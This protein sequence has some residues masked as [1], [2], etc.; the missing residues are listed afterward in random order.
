MTQIADKTTKI[1]LVI[2]ALGIP[3]WS[4]QAPTPGPRPSLAPKLAVI[5]VKD[6]FPPG[7]SGHSI[8]EVVD[9]L[10]ASGNSRKKSEFETSE[11][12]KSRG[13]AFLQQL[14]ELFFV[15]D[16]D[17]IV[18][19]DA[20]LQK[21]K[22][23]LLVHSEGRV[24]LRHIFYDLPSYIGTN[25]FG[26]SVLVRAQKV[27]SYGLLLD[28]DLDNP[29]RRFS[30]S[31]MTMAADRA[32]D[33]KPHLRLVLRCRVTDP[34]VDVKLA[35]DK[36]TFSDPVDMTRQTQLVH[37][38]LAGDPMFV[39][40][41]TG[42]ILHTF[43]PNEERMRLAVEMSRAST[44]YSDPKHPTRVDSRNPTRLLA[45]ATLWSTRTRWVE[46][47]AAKVTRRIEPVY[48]SAAKEA[49]IEGIV[50][51]VALISPEGVI[52]D[53]TLLSGHPLLVPSAEEAV[54]QWRYEPRWSTSRKMTAA[55]EIQV[56]FILPD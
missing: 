33:V 11:T 21:L 17:L 42:E 48:P 44:D 49:R 19:Y 40:N 18:T 27:F 37:V 7:F 10:N 2:I 6:R 22:F 24:M 15:M 45:E 1:L 36:P 14:P 53:L 46:P 31:M 47:Y 29:D 56:P 30:F 43:A 35:H 23:E 34:Q 39:D 54:R 12:Y 20:D 4:A 26:A 9:V 38:T 32:Q 8:T 41:R 52:Q 50:R 3:S 28:K 5:S 51:F 13:G 16:R 25:A 55:T